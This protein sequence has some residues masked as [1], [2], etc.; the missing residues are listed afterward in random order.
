MRKAQGRVFRGDKGEQRAAWEPQADQLEKLTIKMREG[1]QRCQGDRIL[2]SQ[3]KSSELLED[4]GS[5]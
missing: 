2:G 3:I 1:Q 4:G 5:F